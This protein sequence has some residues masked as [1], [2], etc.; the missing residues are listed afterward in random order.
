VLLLTQA[1]A[2]LLSHTTRTSARNAPTLSAEIMKKGTDLFTDYCQSEYFTVNCSA[3]SGGGVNDVILIDSGKYG[4]MNAGR[5]VSGTHGKLGCAV[6][7]TW[8]LN[9][10]CSGRSH[11][12]VYVADPV[13]HSVDPCN[14]DLSSYLEAGYA[15]VT[16][17]N[18][19]T[20]PGLAAAAVAQ[21]V[22]LRLSTRNQILTSVAFVS[23]G[24]FAWTN[25]CPLN[26]AELFAD[27]RCP[28]KN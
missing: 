5:C 11:C 22:N 16:G 7:V 14:R 17:K 2:P 13:L 10:R 28:R 15:C 26:K 20:P 4:R 9:L 18:Y 21:V 1:L 6:D 23:D 19:R 8:Y 24:F 3:I 25:C 27:R 12:R